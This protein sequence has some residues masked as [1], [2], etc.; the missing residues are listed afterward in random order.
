VEQGEEAELFTISDI[1]AISK[2]MILP[3][4][5]MT[6]SSSFNPIDMITPQASQHKQL[7]PRSHKKNMEEYS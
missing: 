2:Q 4:L 5:Q 3:S 1:D 7:P 6:Q